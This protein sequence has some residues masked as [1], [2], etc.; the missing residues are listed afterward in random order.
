MS[1]SKLCLTFDSFFFFQAEDGIRDAQESRG[2]GDVYKR[3][4][5]SSQR[6]SPPL[7]TMGGTPPTNNN[8]NKGE[9]E[10]RQPHPTDRE[11][12]E[13]VDESATTIHSRP[14]DDA[15]ASERFKASPQPVSYT[16]LTLPTK[17]IV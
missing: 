3:Q 16:H 2:L 17:R 8:D 13:H 1:V 11:M 5:P 7:F 4:A 10:D 12:H 9:D 15:F 6:T 14:F